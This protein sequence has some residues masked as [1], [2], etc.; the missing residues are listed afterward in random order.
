MSDCFTGVMKQVDD[1]I[2]KEEEKKKKESLK[3]ELKKVI[4]DIRY[5]LFAFLIFFEG[6]KY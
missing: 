3:K 5:N 1:A 2:T 4:D 6:A